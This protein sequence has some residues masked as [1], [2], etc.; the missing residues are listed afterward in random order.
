MIL[1]GHEAEGDGIDRAV[2]DAVEADEALALAQLGVR[3]AC[4]LAVLQ[5]GIAIDALVGVALDPPHGEA[6][7]VAEKCTERADGAA[8][9]ARNDHVHA[10]EEEQDEP[11]QPCPDMVI[12]L[13]VERVGYQ[14]V[15]AG[16][17]GG[18]HGTMEEADRIEQA[19][20]QA[21]EEGRDDH[22]QQDEVLQLLQVAKAIGLDV[23]LLIPTVRRESG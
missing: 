6:R 18:G 15:D 20:L 1:I 17:D 5:A 19:D 9:E 3:I 7:K 14:Q 22:G 13:H 16:Q 4:A 12:L 10:D 2:I 11:D 23:P 8:E 21:S